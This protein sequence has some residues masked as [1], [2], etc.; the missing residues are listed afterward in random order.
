[1]A[2]IASNKDGST[3]VQTVDIETKIHNADYDLSKY[4]N[5]M[6]LGAV[7]VR[8][9]EKCIGDYIEVVIRIPLGIY[10]DKV[11]PYLHN[12]EVSLIRNERSLTKGKPSYRV[13]RYKAVFLKDRNANL[14]THLAAGQEDAN[15]AGYVPLVLQLIDRSVEVLRV[16]TTYGCFD[17]ASITKKA[18]ANYSIE[19]F[20]SSV[21]SQEINSILIDGKPNMDF[22]DIEKPDNTDKL[23]SL[24]L[25]SGTRVI[26]IPT[27]VQEDSTGVYNSGIGTY[28]QPYKGKKGIYVYSLY[29][30]TKYN[31]SVEK[32]VFLVPLTGALSLG[33]Y[34][35]SYKDNLLRVI[36]DPNNNIVNFKEAAEMAN[37]VGIR[38]TDANAMMKKPV[39]MTDKGPK[40]VR[41][42]L[43]TEVVA[44]ERMDGLN[45]APVRKGDQV[46]SNILRKMSE[47]SKSMGSVMRL[48]WHSADYELIYPGAPCKIVTVG[49]DGKAA[50][51]FGV[52]Q[53][54][55]ASINSSFQT[56]IYAQMT[57]PTYDITCS[58]DVFV[59]K[60]SLNSLANTP[61]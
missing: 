21:L 8:D 29:N 37:G 45:Y 5:I 16:K 1:M 20:L 47:V 23:S 6:M 13:E 28:I 39:E 41:H 61:P 14:P 27:I 32:I 59:L 3:V 35:Y 11:Y 12:T 53:K 7:I 54:V 60:D 51:L 55:D 58:I 56:G 22:V 2:D 44:K 9:Y 4:D 43:N 42:Q 15:Q 48:V 38:N 19:E 50:S 18:T 30:P 34:T 17:K 36:T 33:N 10:L 52:I 49:P 25:P 31:D 46:S 40:A 26:E 24:V 57:K